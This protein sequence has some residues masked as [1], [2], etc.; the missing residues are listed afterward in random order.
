MLPLHQGE[1]SDP[2][3]GLAQKYGH[4][5]HD[6]FVTDTSDLQMQTVEQE[7]QSYVTGHLSN[8]NIDIVK[9]WEVCIYSGNYSDYSQANLTSQLN[10]TVFPMLF[11]IAMDYLPIQASSVPSERVFFV[12]L[13]DRHQET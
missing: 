5:V 3:V 12:Q 1:T 13:Q 7:F 10:E 11:K 6:M 9:Y 8:E 2:L 4:A